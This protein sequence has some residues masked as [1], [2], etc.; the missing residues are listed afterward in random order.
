M[1]DGRS[2]SDAGGDTRVPTSVSY[3]E[4]DGRKIDMKG[5]ILYGYQEFLIIVDNSYNT[6]CG[7]REK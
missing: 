4:K 7:W 1:E 5:I 6:A 2:A 3:K